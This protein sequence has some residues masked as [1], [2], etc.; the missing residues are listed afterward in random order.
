MSTNSKRRPSLLS[1]WLE[2]SER[3]SVGFEAFNVI[4]IAENSS[5]ESE[6][7]T[8]LGGLLRDCMVDPNFLIAA[9]EWLDWPEIETWTMGS[10]PES[11]T[12]RRGS[13]GEVLAT[14][15]MEEFHNYDVPVRKL[16]YRISQGQSLPGTDVVALTWS[17][18]DGITGVCFTEVK[19][20]TTTAFASEAVVDAY[21]Q[22]LADQTAYRPAMLKFI[23][24]RLADM[25][26][27]LLPVFMRYLRDRRDLSDLDSFRM[28]LVWDSEAWEE[29]L[30]SILRD[31]D[32]SV[33]P[34]TVHV[35][36]IEELPSLI[37]EVYRLVPCGCEQSDDT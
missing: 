35:A 3:D 34:L 10:L 24:E 1:T 30:L 12:L 9:Q 11:L 7:I 31:I 6:T 29:K 25:N 37:E 23:A 27:P 36:Q 4:D 26:H 14:A 32:V 17:Q 13:F 2:W 19:L 16:R 20:R 18:D 33:E 21:D 5:P 22:L 8:Y 28:I 15:I